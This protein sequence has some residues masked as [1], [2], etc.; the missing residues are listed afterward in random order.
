MHVKRR[1]ASAAELTKKSRRPNVR[2]DLRAVLRGVTCSPIGAEFSKLLDRLK[3]H[4]DE[5][6][7]MTARLGAP[8]KLMM[9]A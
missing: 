1:P 7:A 4:Y 3:V 9:V 8:Q 6:I 2:V 5:G